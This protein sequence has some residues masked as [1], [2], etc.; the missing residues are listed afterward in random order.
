MEYIKAK[1]GLARTHGIKYAHWV[2]K[3]AIIIC[4]EDGPSLSMFN[5]NVNRIRLDFDTH[6]EVLAA[7]EALAKNLKIV[8]MG[9][10]QQGGE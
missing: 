3:T 8:S 9:V 7:M 1:N 10:N 6:E 2:E 5:D 4:Y